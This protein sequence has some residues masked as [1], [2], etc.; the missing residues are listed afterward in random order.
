M[1]SCVCNAHVCGGVH[2]CVQ[3]CVPYRVSDLGGTERWEVEK[4]LKTLLLLF[5]VSIRLNLLFPRLCSD[6]PSLSKI[7]IIIL[8]LVTMTSPDS[9][10]S[11]SSLKAR[12]AGMGVGW[13]RWGW[14]VLYTQARDTVLVQR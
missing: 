11:L 13:G 14:H 7:T 3:V 6:R 2:T 4:E 10:I 12:M 1:E 5:P 8:A 9:C